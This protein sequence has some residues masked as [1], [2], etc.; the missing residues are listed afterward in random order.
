LDVSGAS[1]EL[2]VMV[3]LLFQTLS[4]PFIADLAKTNTVLVDS[5]MGLYN[6]ADNVPVVVD[7]IRISV[8]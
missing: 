7:A 4:Y 2:N 5:F 6:P 8:R 1:G 3:E